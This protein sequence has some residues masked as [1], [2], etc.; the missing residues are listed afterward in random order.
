MAVQS[1]EDFYDDD[2]EAITNNGKK[3]N[4]RKKNIGGNGGNTRNNYGNTNS[5]PIN[6][7][8]GHRM[9]TETDDE[10]T[11]RNTQASAG[12]VS[13][14]RGRGAH[15]GGRAP[16]SSAPQREW[17]E[18]NYC[19]KFGHEEKDCYTKINVLERGRQELGQRQRVA[20]TAPSGDGQLNQHQPSASTVSHDQ[21]YAESNSVN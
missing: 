5:A 6:Q 12:A 10:R 8:L 13:R 7:A 9:V 1:E 4:G 11:P 15:R 16:R 21:W 17:K 3:Q 19:M 14:G 20:E 18:C 2:V